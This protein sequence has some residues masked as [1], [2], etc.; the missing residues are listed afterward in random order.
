MIPI[1]KKRAIEVSDSILS[2][3]NVGINEDNASKENKKYPNK[4]YKRFSITA[5]YILMAEMRMAI[6]KISIFL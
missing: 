1:T 2:L 6:I 3:L 5:P 4:K